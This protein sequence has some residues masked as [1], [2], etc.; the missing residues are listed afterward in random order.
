MRLGHKVQLRTIKH[1]NTGHLVMG[2][3]QSPYALY[4]IQHHFFFIGKRVLLK[5]DK[6]TS[7]QGNGF[8][9]KVG[10]Y[11]NGQSPEHLWALI[12][13]IETMRS[14]TQKGLKRPNI[15]MKGRPKE[16]PKPK[17]K[18]K[19]QPLPTTRSDSSRTTTTTISHL[20]K[21]P[22]HHW[23]PKRR[24]YTKPKHNHLPWMLTKPIGEN[25]AIQ[26]WPQWEPTLTIPPNPKQN[27]TPLGHDRKTH[28]KSNR[29]I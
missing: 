9:L 7:S 20:R 15:T 1:F 13:Q 22:C 25:W 17:P 19:Q 3:N 2:Q 10:K 29:R 24:Y 4:V 8:Q 27:P 6:T 14:N 5:L 18:Q 12:T 21:P 28:Q 26:Q 11:T 16:S 23:P